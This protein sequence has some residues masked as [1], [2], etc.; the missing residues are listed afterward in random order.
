MDDELH[1]LKGSLPDAQRKKLAT[2]RGGSG[3]KRG[4][5]PHHSDEKA[6]EWVAG[7]GRMG[8]SKD[9]GPI[10]FKKVD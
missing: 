5:N 10:P 4:D 2:M 1:G 8:K 7:H 3:S 6:D 9:F